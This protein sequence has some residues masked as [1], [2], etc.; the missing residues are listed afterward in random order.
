MVT[1][2]DL[3]NYAGIRRVLDDLRLRKASAE[4]TSRLTHRKE[5]AKR[6]RREADLYDAAADKLEERRM[7][8]EAAVS[9]IRNAD[10]R[11][12]VRMRY[13]DGKS[14]REIARRIY[15]SER[16]VIRLIEAALGELCG[17]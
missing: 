3:E 9:G 11:T 2:E 16:T 10:A 1:R 14:N 4:R 8:I 6:A 15:C 5:D 17:G 12:A 7:Q 13:M